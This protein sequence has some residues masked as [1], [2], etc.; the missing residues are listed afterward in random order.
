MVSSGAPRRVLRDPQSGGGSP[1]PNISVYCSIFKWFQG[2][3]VVTG[4]ARVNRI[5][6]RRLEFRERIT[7]AAL[8][9]FES[10]GVAETSVAAIIKEADIAH[11]TF[12]NHFPTK[13]HLLEHIACTFADNAYDT[14][15][16]GFTRQADPGKRIA[17]CLLN[18][19]R[20]LEHVNP[21]YKALLNV[22][23]ISGAAP[24][25]LQLRQKEQ[26]SGVIRQIVSDAGAS[27]LLRA[28]FDVDT[29]T[30]IVV[31]LCVATLLSWSL[32]EGFPIVARMKAMIA[33]INASMF[34]PAPAE[35]PVSA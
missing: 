33:F 1:G 7:Q 5:E 21:H 25:D 18:I 13:D 2:G 31:G 8:R 12:F 34:L 23:L 11:K 24:G 32:E 6:R 28:D 35:A 29:C 4:I 3:V 19:A 16:D 22:Y 14:F 30:E 26:F 27:G 9:L 15:R 20:A 10:Q 17:Y